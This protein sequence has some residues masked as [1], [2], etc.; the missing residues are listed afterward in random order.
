VSANKPDISQIRKYLNG[1]LDARAMHQLERQAQDDPFLMDALEGYQQKGKE[2]QPHL[3]ELQKR[4][5]HRTTAGRKHI[6]LWPAM[7]IAASILLFIS[8]GGWWL[9][10][11]RA[12]VDTGLAP[13]KDNTVVAT[14]PL[15]PAAKKAAPK[16][17]LDIA[18]QASPAP[19]VRP[20]GT[21]ARK[22]HLADIIA[23]SKHTIPATASV[24][25]A[26]PAVSKPA[27]Y[28]SDAVLAAESR[29]K[30]TATTSAGG[31]GSSPAIRIRGASSLVNNNPLYVVDGVPYYGKTPDIPTKEIESVSVV[32]DTAATA[33]Y[34][35]RGASGVILVTT[36]KVK[37]GK[38]SMDSNL[39]AK[40]LNDVLVVS[41]GTQ[42]RKDITGSVSTA[43]PVQIEQALRGR[44][45]GMQA[46]TRDRKHADTLYT[47][48]GQVLAKSDKLP[49]PG[50]SVKIEGTSV[51]TV[52][53]AAGKF[54]IKATPGDALLVNYIGYETEKIKAKGKDSLKVALEESKQ[55]LS[56]VVVVSNGTTTEKE[57]QNAKPQ[58]G[59][60]AFNKYIKENT[61]PI[62]G[63]IGVVRLSFVVNT[64]GALSNFKILKSLS[65]E[66]DKAA[67][68]LL[69]DGPDWAPNSNGK[70]ETVKLRI[71]F[72]L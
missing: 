72:K 39:I 43:K 37:S 53:D 60:G 49:L 54:K 62:N 38:T 5:Q 19:Q 45:A 44:M 46:T 23:G 55:A 33:I 36:K 17:G 10:N 9:I 57:P 15:L 31:V 71:S 6:A 26:N 61:K 25:H 59:W 52:T 29:V 1:E 42:K 28:N 2:Q 41:Y 64:N 34:G 7:S 11:N 51:G 70:P 40:N 47:Y 21:P 13:G 27:G 8:V 32:K 14:R 16:P 50:V 35:S 58:Q 22:P 3:N 24:V 66:A 48:T 30:D 68:K 69:E 63:K 67:V 20:A 4:L 56:E 65:T 12:K 18:K